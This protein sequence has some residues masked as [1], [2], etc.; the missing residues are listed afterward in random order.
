MLELVAKTGL[1]RFFKER[2]LV[3]A[4]VNHRFDDV[5]DHLGCNLD[6]VGK[7]CKSNFRLD[8]PKLCGVSWGVAVLCS[9]RRA[10]RVYLAHC[11]CRHFAF[12]LSADGESRF[13]SEK[14]VGDVF[15]LVLCQFCVLITLCGH[16]EY[17]ARAFAVTARDDGSMHVG[18]AVLLEE[19]MDR[20]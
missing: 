13:S 3:G 4:F 2:D 9:E 1:E 12:E 6:D 16:S 5:L 17:L 14:V 11:H 8:L 7:F 19:T 20:K 15:R 10:E 18:V